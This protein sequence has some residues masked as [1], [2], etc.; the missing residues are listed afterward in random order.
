M[1]RNLSA[2]VREKDELPPLTRIEVPGDEFAEDEWMLLPYPLSWLA[3]HLRWCLEGKARTEALLTELADDE[4]AGRAG[5]V[6][7]R[8]GSSILVQCKVLPCFSVG[9]PASP[10]SCFPLLRWNQRASLW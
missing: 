10:V 2:R 1:K 8:A 7:A 4:R 3:S 9:K 6:G 5:R